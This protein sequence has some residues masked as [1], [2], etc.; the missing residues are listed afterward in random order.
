MPH[1][2]LQSCKQACIFSVVNA[3]LSCLSMTS[4]SAIIKFLSDLPQADS[5]L[6]S[7]CIDMNDFVNFASYVFVKTV[8]RSF[9][10]DSCAH[11]RLWARWQP[12][13]EWKSSTFD[14]LHAT[15]VIDVL[16]GWVDCHTHKENY[17][18]YASFLAHGQNDHGLPSIWWSDPRN[19]HRKLLNS[20]W[21]NRRLPLLLLV[22]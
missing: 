14:T 11:H 22:E 2:M 19:E 12:R 13:G 16:Q 5:L 1:A 20:D 17:R 8:N 15:E 18:P 7:H 9:C 10:I 6:T 4:W 21:Y 3:A